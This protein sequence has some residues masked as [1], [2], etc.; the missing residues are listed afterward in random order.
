MRHTLLTLSTLLVSFAALPQERVGAKKPLTFPEA[1]EQA[2]KAA[3]AD[4]LGAAIAALQAAIKDLQKKQRT[5]ILANLPKP[6][7]WEVEDSGADDA[8]ND[9]AVGILGG[10]STV[11]RHYRNADKMITVEVTANS[12]LMQMMTMLFA[13]PAMIEAEGGE[14]VKYGAHK[15]VLKKV[16]DR[17]QELTLL[18]HDA[19]LVKVTSEGL[20][21]DELLQFFDQ[22]TVDRLEKPLGR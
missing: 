19:H 14:L 18:M 1:I 9:V 11:T 20:T 12:P 3:E 21:G 22:A 8:A 7:G 17:G 15:A 4:K 16:G 5:A 2:K 13:N 10:Q 6:E